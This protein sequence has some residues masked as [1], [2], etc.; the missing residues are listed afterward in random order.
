M[1]GP[2]DDLPPPA[3]WPD[4]TTSL[5]GLEYPET[6]NL[7]YELVDRH[8]VEG[9]GARTAVV[10]SHGT[11]TY[12]ELQRLVNRIAGALTAAGVAPGDRVALWLPNGLSFAACWLAI[13]KIGAIAVTLLPMFRAREVSA[14]LADA[15]PTLLLSAPDLVPLARELGLHAGTR[16]I[17]AGDASLAQW[18]EGLSDDPPVVATRRDDLSA[19]LYTVAADG[20]LKG[21]AHSHGQVLASADTY[22][23]LV[24]DAGATD[25]FGGSPPASLAFGLGALLVFPLRAGA[26]ALLL[27]GVTVE[28]WLRAIETHRITV[29]VGAPTF[30]RL[31]LKHPRLTEC[32]FGS[33]RAAVSAG[34]PLPPEIYREWTTRTGVE[35][36]DG[37]GTTE[38]FHIFLSSR[39]GAVRA[40]STGLP[41]P[42]YDVRVVN[43]RLEDVPRGTAGLLAVRGPTGCRYWRHD[44]HQRAYVRQGWNLTGDV[45]VQDEAGYYWFQ[46]RA[47]A[48]IVSG[49][50]NIAAP[51]VEAVLRGHPSV[52]H[53]SVTG[54]P[55]PV[56]GT[57]VTAS[58]ALRAGV[59][60]G[61][62]LVEAIQD[63]VRRTIAPYKCPK[64]IE[65]RS[66]AALRSRPAP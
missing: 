39:K 55:D 21:A 61:Q 6:I 51:E 56:R 23:R 38:M 64:R 9:H 31:A 8:V 53:A 26:T 19:I 58:V 66:A 52:A 10:G 62:A 35:L 20:T 60:P 11:T 37:I 57:I 1:T 44:D 7:G 16:V 3:L 30:Y 59:E 42:G 48:L 50:Y 24:L 27:G 46:S 34:E 25:V 4:F 33:L 12:A 5:P 29:L 18:T 32:R 65:F 17:D 41:V 49:G 43:E 14:I 36:L 45:F 2:S 15:E 40:G 47:D 54:R 13:Q 28:G 63:H 22:S